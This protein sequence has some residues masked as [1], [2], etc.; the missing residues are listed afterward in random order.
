M[1][2]K[3]TGVCKGGNIDSVVKNAMY[4]DPISCR[5]LLGLPTPLLSTYIATS[6]SLQEKQGSLAVGTLPTSNDNNSSTS[7]LDM[8]SGNAMSQMNNR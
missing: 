1:F 4:L 7:F 8:S 2:S 6:I 3:A 5:I